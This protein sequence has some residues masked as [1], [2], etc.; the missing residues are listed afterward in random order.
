MNPAC[1][2][3][4]V[5]RTYSLSLLKQTNVFLQH[6]Q[7]CSEQS[8]LFICMKVVENTRETAWDQTK[9]STCI[10]IMSSEMLLPYITYTIIKVCNWLLNP[11]G[12]MQYLA[13]FE[14]KM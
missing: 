5:T 14:D 13:S 11:I 2:Y 10:I 3:Y 6:M 8:V 4:S 12:F 1:L 9:R 7:M